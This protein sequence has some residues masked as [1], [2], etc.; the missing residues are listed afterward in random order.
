[1]C[2]SYNAISSLSLE[3]GHLNVKGKDEFSRTFR[4]SSCEICYAQLG[5]VVRLPGQV[6]PTDEVKHKSGKVGAPSILKAAAEVQ[7]SGDV[8]KLV[9]NAN[10][11]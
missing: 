2:E 6:C 10:V 1:M 8:S 7:F 9:W 11:F 3:A 4:C 5:D